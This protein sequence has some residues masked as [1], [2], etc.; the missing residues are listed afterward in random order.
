VLTINGRIRLRRRW[1][2]SAETG[3]L[4]PA[5]GLLD[6]QGATITP[7]VVE[8]ASRENLSASSFR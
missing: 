5:D 4:A 3:S 2:Y 6:R 7:G 1:W 8:M